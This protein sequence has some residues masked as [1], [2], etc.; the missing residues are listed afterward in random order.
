MKKIFN[1]LKENFKFIILYLTICAV[2]NIP[3]PYY[4]EAPGGLI[5]VEDRVEIADKDDFVG[6]FNLSYVSTLGCNLTSYL[7]S[8]LKKDWE[9]VKKEEF[10]LENESSEDYEARANIMLN[11]ANQIATYVAFKKANKDVEIKDSKLYVYYL[12]QSAKSNLKVGDIIKK[13]NDKDVT[14]L[15]ELS[16]TLNEINDDKVKFT[17]L[18]KN[19]MLTKEAE[20]ITEDDKRMLGIAFHQYLD[21]ETNPKVTFH[22]NRQE[23]GPSGG[24]IMTLAIYNQLVDDITGGKKIAGTGTIDYDGTVG[25]IDGVKYKIMGANKEGADIF[26]VPVDNYDEALKVKKEKNY[27]LELV[28]VATFDDAINYLKNKL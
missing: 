4:I 28:K 8:Y 6:S 23:S 22:F 26:F 5:D 11:D 20:F 13:V 12:T 14:T 2:L 3:L 16:N 25:A 10:V 24:L 18:R 27:S 19:K 15:E 17:V 1:F 7:F 9:L 21:I